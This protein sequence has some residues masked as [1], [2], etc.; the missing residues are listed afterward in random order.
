[1]L[2][3]YCHQRALQC[4]QAACQ[5]WESTAFRLQVEGQLPCRSRY[6]PGSSRP[7][8]GLQ[9]DAGHTM[10]DWRPGAAL[11]YRLGWLS[12]EK[13][14]SY[15][16]P[17]R[18][19]RPDIL[20][21]SKTMS[22]NTWQF[23]PVRVIYGR[24][25]IIILIFVLSWNSS[26]SDGFPPCGWSYRS[27]QSVCDGRFHLSVARMIFGRATMAR[28]PGPSSFLPS[29]LCIYVFWGQ[30]KKKSTWLPF[31]KTKKLLSFQTLR[32]CAYSHAF[33]R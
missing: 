30:R 7:W 16:R 12:E 15:W 27:C 20:R 8:P 2:M 1:M 33:V 9:A 28:A 18:P 24:L 22:A 4:I 17:Y 32:F 3:G 29:S 25:Q 5:H 26:V 6:R 10:R 21:G 19:S 31:S 23:D 13:W 14:H 11:F